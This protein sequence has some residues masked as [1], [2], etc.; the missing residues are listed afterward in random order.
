MGKLKM[1]TAMNAVAGL[2]MLL[3]GSGTTWAADM[4]FV[5]RDVGAV[6]VGKGFAF[7]AAGACSPFKGY[8]VGQDVLISGTACGTSDT[9]TIRFN[10][11]YVT[12][13]GRFGVN[14]FHLDR[15]HSGYD[16][17][18]YGYFTSS[19]GG[20][21]DVRVSYYNTIRCPSPLTLN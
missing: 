21:W 13:D 18:G 6:F 1:K 4:C 14:E 5:Q 3:L 11:N 16:K 10:L 20:G 15:L 12:P 9:H 8:F 2:S 7:P 17:A 19:D